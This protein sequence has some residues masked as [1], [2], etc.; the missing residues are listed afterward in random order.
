M[1]E[2]PHHDNENYARF[3]KDTEEKPKEEEEV[4][5]NPPSPQCVPK[6]D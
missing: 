1:G 4:T 2:R 6:V 3:L 5:L